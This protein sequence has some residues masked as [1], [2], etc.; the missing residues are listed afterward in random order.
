M[1]TDEMTIFDNSLEWDFEKFT[2]V[3]CYLQAY[4]DAYL[5]DKP[6]FFNTGGQLCRIPVTDELLT[7][8]DIEESLDEFHGEAEVMQQEMMLDAD[9]EPLLMV[10]REATGLTLM[11]DPVLLNA[12]TVLPD[13]A[14]DENDEL[15]SPVWIG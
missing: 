7:R 14:E 10:V 6:E 12:M 13:M 4:Y 5:A 3:I 15:D 1:N 8:M 2:A 11:I 9:E